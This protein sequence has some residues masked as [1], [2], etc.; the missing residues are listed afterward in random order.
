MSGCSNVSVYKNDSITAYG[1]G[2]DGQGEVVYYLV[3]IDMHRMPTD[4]A[5]EIL[6]VLPNVENPVSLSRLSYDFVSKAMQPWQPP[7]EWSE[8]LKQK[9]LD[10]NKKREIEDF[11]VKGTYVAFKNRVL[12]QISLCSHC[13]GNRYI[14]ASL[15][16]KGSPAQYR[17]P[18]TESQLREIFGDAISISTQNEIY[19]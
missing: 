18:L 1:S 12:W 7:Q 17:L 8:Y 11:S 6:L 9:T 13:E 4:L 10:E 19:Y 3:R 16:R 14:T 15:S 5:D 2:L